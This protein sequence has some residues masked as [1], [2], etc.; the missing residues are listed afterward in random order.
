MHLYIQFAILSLMFAGTIGN[1]CI[2][3]ELRVPAFTAYMLPNPESARAS[4]QKGITRWNDPTQSV[5]WYGKF[6]TPGEL[7]LKAELCLPLDIKSR[8]KLN[9]DEESHEA[10]VT[11]LG[12]DQPV[13]ADFGVFR[14]ATAGHKRMQLES[15]NETK[16][17]IGPPRKFR[18]RL[19]DF[20][21]NVEPIP[22]SPKQRY[23]FWSTLI[24]VR[25]PKRTKSVE[26][27]RRLLERIRNLVHT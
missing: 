25:N 19:C 17:P 22:H 8:L 26:F 2:A 5:N 14:I 18:E 20:S 3:E 7:K 12:I 13:I 10:T 21:K 1:F 6:A 24:D 27:I 11:G 23:L 15:L 4:E 16:G 9:I